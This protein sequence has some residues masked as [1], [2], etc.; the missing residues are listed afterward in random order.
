MFVCEITNSP[1]YKVSLPSTQ[2][3]VLQVDHFGALGGTEEC[4]VILLV[5]YRLL[6]SNEPFKKEVVDLN[7]KASL[8][9]VHAIPG[10]PATPTP[11]LGRA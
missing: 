4:N 8:Y 7:L 6:P 5:M 9:D 11:S 1:K 3:A 10:T 2:I